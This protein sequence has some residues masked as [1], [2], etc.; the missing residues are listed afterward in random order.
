MNT[1]VQEF[2]RKKVQ[3]IARRPNDTPEC[4]PFGYLCWVKLQ[5][6]I[7]STTALGDSA[8]RP[9]FHEAN[10]RLVGQEPFEAEFLGSNLP[11]GE[12]GPVFFSFRRMSPSS[13]T[14][15]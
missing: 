12:Q 2:Q 6:T 9:R 11:S 14:I 15:R 7:S 5:D 13:E 10:L 4:P 1:Y 3:R 8:E